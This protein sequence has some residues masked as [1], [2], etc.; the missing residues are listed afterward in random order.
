MYFL[1]YTAQ[2]KLIPACVFIKEKVRAALKCL[3]INSPYN[4]ALNLKFKDLVKYLI[5]K[6]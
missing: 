2:K 6:I 5:E 1:L 3:C 4:T